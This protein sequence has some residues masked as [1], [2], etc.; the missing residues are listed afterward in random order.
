MYLVER[1]GYHKDHYGVKFRDVSCTRAEHM[2][3]PKHTHKQ[4]VVSWCRWCCR[5]AQKKHMFK[6]RQGPVDW[7]FC[8][9]EH[10]ALWFEYRYKPETYAL[11]KML[12]AEREIH[13]QGRTM[14]EEISRLV[15]KESH[16]Q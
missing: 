16:E 7:Y 1:R 8:D 4:C 9:D 3:V 14:S 12:P 10:A 6:V 5:R 13:L 2:F 11:C 15:P